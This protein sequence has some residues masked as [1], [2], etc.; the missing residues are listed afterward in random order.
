M[1]LCLSV[2]EHYGQDMQIR[3]QGLDPR[4][5][6]E[7]LVS[8][9]DST[10]NSAAEE[11]RLNFRIDESDVAEAT[12]IVIILHVKEKRSYRLKLS[13]RLASCREV[14]F[15]FTDPRLRRSLEYHGRSSCGYW[16]LVGWLKAM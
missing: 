6:A 2:I 10:I 13:E 5:S 14:E 15:S 7:V 11:G 3:L 4:V 16:I 8:M 9:P 12:Q 1:T